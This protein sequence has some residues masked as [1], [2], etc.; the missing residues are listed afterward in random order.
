LLVLF[1]FSAIL[2]LLFAMW[3]ALATGLEESEALQSGGSWAIKSRHL[4]KHCSEPRTARL[5]GTDLDLYFCPSL[6]GTDTVFL[7]NE[8]GFVEYVLQESDDPTSFQKDVW[9]AVLN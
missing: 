5:S 4:V 7:V 8:N 2:L 9:E 3:H 1:G 6:F